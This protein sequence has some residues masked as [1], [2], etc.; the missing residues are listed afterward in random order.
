V[1]SRASS[2]A[3]GGSE[4]STGRACSPDPQAPRRASGSETEEA[5]AEVLLGSV[6]R[7]SPGASRDSRAELAG[8]TSRPGRRAGG[9]RPSLH[10]HLTHGRHPR[11]RLRLVRRLGRRHPGQGRR[12][13]RDGDLRPDHG[14]RV[15]G[16]ARK[17]PAGPVS[18]SGAP[19]GRHSHSDDR[20]QRPA[21]SLVPCA[22]Q[23]PPGAVQ[24]GLDL[25]RPISMRSPI[26]R[27]ESPSRARITNARAC[28]G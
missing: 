8:R 15:S 10:R 26:S 27:W 25:A 3:G 18:V 5:A 11:G 19:G 9:T 28:V 14:S 4:V 23:R 12:H 7:S 24:E 22:P 2:T 20:R 21:L 13:D 16:L 17:L 1:V 6:A